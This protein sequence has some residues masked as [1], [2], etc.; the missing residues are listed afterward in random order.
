MHV[1]EYWKRCILLEKKKTINITDFEDTRNIVI[2]F[3]YISLCNNFFFLSSLFSCICLMHKQFPG[4]KCYRQ[5]PIITHLQRHDDELLSR[6]G[7][8]HPELRLPHNC[9]TPRG[10]LTQKTRR[11]LRR[12]TKQGWHAN[13][14]RGFS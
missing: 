4:R 5:F 8:F 1:R 6:L 11:A 14:P 3:S 12:Q 2:H 9:E 13:E 7:Q 10:I